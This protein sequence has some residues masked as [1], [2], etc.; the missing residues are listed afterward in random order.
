MQA[1]S[2]GNPLRFRILTRGE[3]DAI[4]EKGDVMAMFVGH[5][6]INGFVGHYQTSISYTHQAAA[7]MFTAP[8]WNG[9]CV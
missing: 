6:H 2:C 9:R 1:A 7:S 8:A 4:A 5:D 3:F